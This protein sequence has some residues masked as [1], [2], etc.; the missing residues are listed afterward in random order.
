[1]FNI[2]ILALGKIKDPSLAALFLEYAK[3]LKPYARLK[4]VELTPRAFSKNDQFKT[5]NEEGKSI[6]DFLNKSVKENGAKVYLLAERGQTF[7]SPAFAA[8]LEQNQP[9][10]L[11]LGGA[12]GFSASLYEKYPQISL[13][14]LTFPHELARVIL[15]EQIYRAATIINGK[16]YHY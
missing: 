4:V 12:L 6:E 8:W 14:A 10:I 5:K 2:T 1:M 7:A 13:S 11:V 9:L 16:D 3:R 15:V